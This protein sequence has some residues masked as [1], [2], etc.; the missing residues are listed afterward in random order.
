MLFLIN[1]IVLHAYKNVLSL[2]YHRQ[3]LARSFEL[4]TVIMTYICV[5][6]IVTRTCPSNDSPEGMVD[7]DVY[8]C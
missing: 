1:K 5:L 6:Y 8:T 3:M 4:E 2:F 7:T